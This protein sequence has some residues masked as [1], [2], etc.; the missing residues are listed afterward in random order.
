MLGPSRKSNIDDIPGE[1]VLIWKRSKSAGKTR[2]C[3]CCTQ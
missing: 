3:D 2:E 1:N